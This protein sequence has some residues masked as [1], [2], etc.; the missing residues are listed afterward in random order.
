[1]FSGGSKYDFSIIGSTIYLFNEDGTIFPVKYDNG[2]Y[3]VMPALDG[4]ADNYGSFKGSVTADLDGD[5]TDE[6]ILGG[7]DNPTRVLVYE[8]AGDGSDN[9]GV[10]DGFGGFLPNASTDIVAGD[11]IN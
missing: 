10:D 8:Y 3:T 1:M 11:G 6:I 5:G 4:V 2:S 9:M 7:W